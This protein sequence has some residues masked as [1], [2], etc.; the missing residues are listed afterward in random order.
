MKKLSIYIKNYLT[1]KK[2]QGMFEFTEI[3]KFK[4]KKI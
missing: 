3:F 1:M 4:K 2:I